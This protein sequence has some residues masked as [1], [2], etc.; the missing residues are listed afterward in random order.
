VLTAIKREAAKDDLSLSQ[1][2][3]KTPDQIRAE[4][5]ALETDA[6]KGFKMAA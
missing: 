6:A 2:G 4:Q 1:A 5:K 3:Y